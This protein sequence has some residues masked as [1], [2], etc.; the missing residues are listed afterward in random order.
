MTENLKNC[1]SV[2]TRNWTVYR[3][4]FIANIS[5]T[6]A[7]PSLILISLGLGL[8]GF[9]QQ[10]EGRSYMAFLAPGL[11]ASTA[12]FTSFF[13]SSYGFYIRMTFES[14]FKA[15]LTTPIT[16]GQ[17]ILGEYI[18]NFLKGAMMA[19]G[20]TLFLLCFGLAPAWWSVFPAALL[21]GVIALPC[22][23]LGLLASSFVRNIN[24][25]QT[26]YSFLIAPIFYLSG[27]FFPLTPMPE[28]F[29]WA[30]LISPFT[31]GVRLMQQLFWHQLSWESVIVHGGALVAF[32]LALGLWSAKRLKAQL[33]T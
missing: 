19:S 30:V 13:E 14:V 16:A 29:R 27:V 3:K 11:V 15:M 32:S 4:D 23:A 31:H 10:V 28:A 25:F 2:V 9:V 24:Q 12:L 7:D 18:W 8:G 22:A 20:V 33:V 6:V 5:P 21:G 17:I 26:V 1:W